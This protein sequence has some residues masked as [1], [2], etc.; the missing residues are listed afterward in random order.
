MIMN[1]EERI[2]KI[3]ERNH[4]VETDKAWEISKSRVIIL[5]V[6]TYISMGFIFVA[7]KLSQPWINALI[8]SI[9]FLLSTMTM[10]YFKRWWIKYIYK[11]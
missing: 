10:P 9:G 5:G 7:L 11:K 2:A 4:R 3:E 6:V 8:A 1:L